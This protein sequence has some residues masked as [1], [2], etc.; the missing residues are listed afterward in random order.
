[1]QGP[2]NYSGNETTIFKADK[3]FDKY[4]SNLTKQL[5]NKA[6]ETLPEY[7]EQ[8]QKF[9]KQK[10]YKR[11]RQVAHTI[12]GMA[13]NIYTE[14]LQ[15]NAAKLEKA[16]QEKNQKKIKIYMENIKNIYEKTLQKLEEHVAN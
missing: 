9:Y 5:I 14:A 2:E 12:K 15:R 8:L 3:L 13:M 16:A 10:D 6:L 4:D 1:M 11:L 7:Y